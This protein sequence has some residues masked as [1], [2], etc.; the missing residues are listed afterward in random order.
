MKAL[1]AS[2]A[3]ASLLAFAASPLV[4]A[5]AGRATPP[6]SSTRTAQSQPPP[7]DGAWPRTYAT[8]SGARVVLYQP[9]VASWV[10]HRDMTLYAAVS[11]LAAGQQIPALG[12]IKAENHTQVAL[13]DRLVNFSEFEITEANFPTL[14]KESVEGVVAEIVAAIP[15]EQRVIALDR[16]LAMVDTSQIAPKNVD[17]VK[18]DPPDV[19]FSQTPAILVNLDG[20]PIWSPIAQNDLRFAV[21]TNWDLFEHPPS[22]TFYLRVEKS[23]LTAP[24]I[25][26]PW[27]RAGTLPAG[28]SA[29]PNDGNWADVRAA[30]PGQ[31]FPVGHMPVVLVSE[32]PAEVILLDGAPLYSPVKGTNLLWVSNTDSDLFRLGK[33]GPLYYLVAGRWFSAPDFSGPWTFATP[34]LPADFGRIPLEH[35]RSR[36]LASVPGTRQAAEAVLLAEVPQTAIVN[37]REITAPPVGYQGNPKFQPIEQTTMSRAVNTDKDIFRVADMFYLCFQ[38]VWFV[39][40]TPTGPWEVADSVPN[41]IYQIPVGSPA[42]NVTYVRVNHADEDSVEF[43]ADPAYMGLMV[44]W[45]VPVWGTG[46]YYPPYVGG[47]GGIPGYF[48][49]YPTFGYGAHYNPWSGTYSRGA[50]VYGPYGGAGYGARYNPSTST[51]SRGAVAYG[52]SGARGA[53]LAY[54]P[55][56]GL[57]AAPG[58]GSGVYGS[59]GSTAVKRGDQWAQTSRATT[60]ATGTTGRVTQGSGGGR[61]VSGPG[62]QGSTVVGKSGSG[63]VFAG[64]DGN[65]YRKQGGTWQKYGSGG[66]NNVERPTGT[67]GP[68]SEASRG[69]MDQLNRDWGARAEGTQRMRD[70]GRAGSSGFASYRPSVGGTRG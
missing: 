44:A 22:R 32:K 1:A 25:Q 31:A 66:W 40:M 67:A 57:A 18:A 20:D 9:Q 23:W 21:N 2:S 38:G 45:G 65:V 39:G 8:A 16:V 50:A 11:Y 41:E 6:A 42:H 64:N 48:P 30:V 68:G 36:V 46:Y 27:R 55:R 47:V 43:A 12:T 3:V 51:Y 5:Q 26:G 17:G 29:L 53:V 61:A 37:R 7:V 33:D 60:R 70:S 13:V 10:N 28:F 4:A 35:P 62:P 56:T 15:R 24:S 69:T 52:P 14:P 58:Q 34:T 49:C 59:W 63:D 54:N 19:F